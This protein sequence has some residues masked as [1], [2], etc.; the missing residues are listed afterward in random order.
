MYKEIQSIIEN[1]WHEAAITALGNLL[2][3]YPDFAQGYNDLG[4]LYFH[5]GDKEKALENYR[6]SV[7]LQPDN[8]AFLK[9][10]ANFYYAEMN[11][12]NEALQ[13]YQKVLDAQPE[14]L[15]ALM[16]TGNLCIA[17][18]RFDEARGWYRKILEIE[19]W[20]DEA[21]TYLDKLES[22]LQGELNRR[23][24]EASHQR[25][26]ELLNSGD[27]NGAIKELETLIQS[28]PD[29]AVAHN[30]IAVMYYN[31]GNK[32]KTL[33]HYEEAVRL[34]PEDITFQKNLADFY[35][36]ELGRIEDALEI[37]LKVLTENPTDIETLMTAGYV[38]KA[39][40][41]NEDAK[42]FFDRILD[43]EPWNFEANDNL[44]E[45]N[46]SQMDNTDISFKNL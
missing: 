30:D 10:L 34:E 36:I 20:N 43:I 33:Q 27:I 32:D 5:L 28:D 2:V 3:S 21:Q 44:N 16:I 39:V 4:A 12:V 41:K 9:N 6:E 25:S 46:P 8:I 22:S 24:S 45:L 38:C 13:Y 19:P 40:N 15:E 26:Q 11:D 35:C 14:D 29:S 42:I 17:E 23:G 31:I 18:H 37:Y 1:G 7:K